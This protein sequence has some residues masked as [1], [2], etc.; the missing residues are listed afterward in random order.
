MFSQAARQVFDCLERRKGE[1]WLIG[2]DREKFDRDI[3]NKY[4]QIREISLSST[5]TQLKVII[6]RE[7]AIDF[8]VDFLAAIAAD[9]VVFLGDPTWVDREWQEVLDLVR[10]NLILG[11]KTKILSQ[12]PINTRLLSNSICISTGGSSGKIRFA[13]HTW[14]TLTAAV[15]GFYYYFDLNHINS[16]CVLP[17][18]HVSGLMQFLRSFLSGGK[19]FVYSYNELKLNINKLQ[20]LNLNIDDFYISLVP[21]QLKFILEN[22]PIWLSQFKTVFVGGAATWKEL[23]ISATKYR[24]NLAPTYGMTETAA[25]IATLKPEYFLSIDNIKD[26]ENTRNNNNC[27]RILP[28]AKVEIRGDA[29]EVLETGRSGIICIES[30]SLFWGYYDRDAIELPERRKTY[31][32]DDLGYLDEAEHLYIIGRNSQKII[33]GGKN[34]FPA[35][36]EAVILGTGLVKDVCAIGLADEYWGQVVTV[37]CVPNADSNSTEIQTA[38]RGRLSNYKYPKHWIIVDSLVRDRKGKLN[39]KTIEKIALELLQK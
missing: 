26:R 20:D 35:E 34:V 12:Y 18:H 10:P 2:C 4:Q 25:Q 16:F 5:V 32:T 30:K 28:H 1:A 17:L 39:Y 9:C 27:G 37:V 15:M 3:R 29:G 21:T 33:T 22:N 36:I 24:I 6:V 11:E 19:F 23:L 14:E 13:I 7:R 38:V 8:L 31:I